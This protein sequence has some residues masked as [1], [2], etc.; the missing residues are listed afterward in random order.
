MLVKNLIIYDSRLIVLRS[1]LQILSV[2]S[3][4]SQSVSFGQLGGS[5]GLRFLG[6][7]R[8]VLPLGPNGVPAFDTP[9]PPPFS[10][11]ATVAGMISYN[12]TL[13]HQGLA[14]AIN[15][16]YVDSTPITF[17]RRPDTNFALDY[18]GSC[19]GET[20]VLEHPYTTANGPNVL[21]YWACQSPPAAGPIYYLYLEGVTGTF[22]NTTDPGGIPP[23]PRALSASPNDGSGHYT[24]PTG[25]YP[26]PTSDLKLACTISPIQA[27]IYPVTY[28]SLPRIFSSTK[29]IANATQVYSRLI[30]RSLIE[31]GDIINDA[32]NF[33]VNLVAE[34]VI[35]VGAR[36]FGLPRKGKHP[37][38][39]EL[40][41]WMIRGILEYEVRRIN[42][43]PR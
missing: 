31:L 26:G 7:I 8:G 38:Y 13:E 14:S 33:H 27:A 25:L 4:N 37:K 36:S 35:T 5:D 39:L 24:G 3:D 15:C 41:E 11:S 18:N 42:F 2:I 1:S 10:N 17:H 21:G 20:D 9:Q 30:E 23:I 16:S 29:S 32:Q 40:Y 22:T 34:S 12:Y 28:Q 43:F 19:N 6:P